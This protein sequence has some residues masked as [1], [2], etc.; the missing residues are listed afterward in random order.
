VEIRGPELLVANT[1]W[2]TRLTCSEAF[3]VFLAICQY[4]KARDQLASARDLPAFLARVAEDGNSEEL[5]AIVPVILRFPM[6]DQ[7][8]RQIDAAG[9]FERFCPRVVRSNK[10][11]LRVAAALLV[12]KLARI[13]WV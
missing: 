6:T 10:P 1:L 2:M 4:P 11:Q 7:F 8:I 12:D 5:D 9:F 3:L 13:A